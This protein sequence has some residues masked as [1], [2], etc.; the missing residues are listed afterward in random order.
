MADNVSPELTLRAHD[1]AIGQA[2]Y[3]GTYRGLN[4]N[5]CPSSVECTAANK[6]QGELAYKRAFD[7]F[8]EY[9]SSNQLGR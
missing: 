8:I 2:N 5:N 3:C 1:Y 6:A 7:S 9:H 4:H